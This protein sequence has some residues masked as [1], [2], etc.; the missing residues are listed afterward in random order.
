MTGDESPFDS[1][2]TRERKRMLPSVSEVV[3][4]LAQRSGG[5]D[6]AQIFRAARQVCADELMRVKDGLEAV[7]AEELA[8]RAASYLA[9][10]FP[11]PAPPPAAPAPPPPPVRP[12]SLAPRPFSSDEPFAETTGA[13]DLRWEGETRE[14]LGAEAAE[15]LLPVG[16]GAVP[17]ALPADEES[18]GAASPFELD[19]P[20]APP[21]L[22]APPGV[23][24]S[25]AAG[26]LPPV[27]VPPTAPP[28]EIGEGPGE[29]TISRLEREAASVAFA[30]VL[31]GASQREA[32]DVTVAAPL[33]A[34]R[35]REEEMTVAAPLPAPL[36]PPTEALP[37]LRF[38]EGPETPAPAEPLPDVEAAATP[39]SDE[40]SEPMPH[41]MPFEAEA[42]VAPRGGRPW[43]LVVGLLVLA[44][45]AIAA[46]RFLGAKRPTPGPERPVVGS[47]DVGTGAAPA[48]ASARVETPAPPPAPA[49]ETAGAPSTGG[50][51]LPEPAVS[52]APAPT[53][54]VAATAVAPTAVPPTRVPTTAVPTVAPTAVPTVVPTAVPTRPARQAPAPAPVAVSARPA[55]AGELPRQSRAA[56]LLSPEWSGKAPAFV[57]HFSSYKDRRLADADAAKLAKRFGREAFAVAVDLGEKGTYFR[58]VVGGFATAEEALAYREELLAQGTPNVGFVYRVSGK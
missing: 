45:A 13:L 44:G 42:H 35:I 55:A 22:P 15:P 7:P 25:A 5:A 56:P 8:E 57:L 28:E 14:P 6:P 52:T 20:P 12:I 53:A 11:Q 26:S 2:A 32:E 1:T 38:G 3:R 50:E 49:T 18:A 48:T 54:P 10:G 16:G 33:P 24:V 37:P 9:H 21:P 29:E 41:R 23:V 17:F 27:P 36:A 51:K 31:P 58:S 30:S 43:L 46:Y 4:L 47:S 19:E 40:R 34:P 39:P